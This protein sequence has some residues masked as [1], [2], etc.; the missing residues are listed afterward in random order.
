[1]HCCCRVAASAIAWVFKR[2]SI[3]IMH[4]FS[5]LV[6]VRVYGRGL[7]VLDFLYVIYTATAITENRTWCLG[8]R[9][10]YY[11]LFYL[12]SMR[13]EG[14]E[15]FGGGGWKKR[16]RDSE[17]VPTTARKSHCER[18]LT[19]KT[20]ITTNRSTDVSFHMNV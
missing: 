12:V 18:N 10:R 1:M 5:F 19:N 20:S 4:L 17:K 2:E 7:F 3:I 15:N 6:Y 8:K 9:Y 16:K 13:A 14:K 11:A